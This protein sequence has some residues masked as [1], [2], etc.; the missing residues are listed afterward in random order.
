M[1]ASSV[2]SRIL[3]WCRR[4]SC[5]HEGTSEVENLPEHWGASL[6][7]SLQ[8]TTFKSQ[9]KK[10]RIYAAVEDD[11]QCFFC[12]TVHRLG[13][14][15]RCRL[16]LKLATGMP[17]STWS[18]LAFGSPDSVLIGLSEVDNGCQLWFRWTR[19]LGCRVCFK[20]HTFS[21]STLNIKVDSGCRL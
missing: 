11:E 12:N 16:L 19:Q 8:Q 17:T 14:W 10:I 5:L 2:S 18:K 15:S 6:F 9:Q 3:G 13:Y 21:F 7:D 1:A 4:F 20:N